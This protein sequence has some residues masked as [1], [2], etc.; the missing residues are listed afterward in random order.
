MSERTLTSRELN[1]ALLS[2]Q[3]LLRR[4]SF[5][6]AQAL[7]RIGGI[8]AQYAPSMYVG[9]WS[10]I[11][12]LERANVTRALKRGAAVQATL[13]RAT[14]HLVARGDYWPFEEAV[15]GARRA[16]Y[17]RATPDAPSDA[18]MAHAVRLL[19]QRLS[20]GPAR[21]AELEQ[22]LGK[23]V[24][25]AI[26][27]WVSLVRLPPSGT[28]ERRRADLYGTA[29]AWIGS[30]ESSEDAG[31]ARL[32]RSYLRGFGPAARGEIANY[33]GLGLARIDAALASLEPLRRFRAEDGELLYD[34]PRA[35]LP[36]AETPAP[37]R[38]LPTWDAT[39]LVHARRT[40]ILPE[41]YRGLVFT[42]KRPQSVGTFLVD[43]AVAGAWRPDGERIA[44]EPFEEIAAGPWREVEREAEALA[45]FYA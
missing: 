26:G 12:G 38:F 32:V 7:E 39:L 9:L 33:A 28:W 16:V 24:A 35:A 43:G 20:A 10:R 31:T 6:V 23:P 15:H 8:Q 34:V 40:G 13:M 36:A 22:L 21:R 42:T 30:S 19:D 14:I 5:G 18:A 1:R 41:E 45:R 25:R 37:V 27:M 29:D 2:R 44:L 4:S 17:Q 3:L 11:A